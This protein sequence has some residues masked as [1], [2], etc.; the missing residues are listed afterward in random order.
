MATQHVCVKR[1]APPFDQ[2]IVDGFH[3]SSDSVTHYFLTHAHADHTTGLHASWHAGAIHCSPITARILRATL[4][5]RPHLLHP[6][7]PGETRQID[8]VAVTA[9]DAHHCP[10]ALMFLFA[11]PRHAALHTGDCRAS[12]LLR[13]QLGAAL[14]GA[15]LGALYLDT[16]YAAPRHAFPPQA[17]AL[18]AVDRLV[19]AELAREPATLFVVGSYSVGKEA[20]IAAA[21]AAAGGRALVPPRRAQMLRLC[22]EWDEAVHADA[23]ADDVRVHVTPLGAGGEA[24]AQLLAALR[25]HGGRFKAAVFVRPTGWT[26]SEAMWRDGNLAPRVWAENGG[27]TRVYGVPYSEHSAFPELQELVRM[28][29][30]RLLVPTVNAETRQKRERLVAL[31][32]PLLDHSRDKCKLDWH[33]KGEG[34]ASASEGEGLGS[35]DVETQR[36]LWQQLHDEQAAEKGTDDSLAPPVEAAAAAAAAAEAM[37]EG[38]AEEE[39]EKQAEEEEEKQAEDG[40][41]LAVLA[42]LGEGT[43]AA[44]VRSLL[45]SGGDAETAIAIHFGANEGKVPAAYTSPAAETDLEA[46]RAAEAAAGGAPADEELQLPPGTVAWVLGKEFRL[47]QSREALHARLKA[48]GAAVVGEGRRH[49]K[50]EVTLIVIA[51]GAEVGAVPRSACPAAAVVRESWVVRRA[52]ALRGG[53]IAPASPAPPA[54][55]QKKR[56]RAPSVA[57]GEK[58]AARTRGLSAAASARQARALSERLYLIEQRDESATSPSGLLTHRRTFAVLGSTGNVYTVAICRLPSCTCV[59]HTER[60][61]V[62]KHLLFVYHKVL[63][64]PH[65]SVIPVQRA[66]LRSELRSILSSAAADSSALDAATLASSAVRSAYAQAMG[67]PAAPIPSGAPRAPPPDEPCAICFEEID[68]EARGDEQRTARCSHGCGRL[69]HADCLRRWFESGCARGLQCPV[70]RARCEVAAEPREAGEEAEVD[71]G[72]LNLRALQPG[73]QRARDSSTYSSWLEVHERNREAASL[74]SGAPLTGGS[75]SQHD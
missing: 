59:D 41:V 19:R 37:E 64:V 55:Q 12:P 69:Y 27:A 34:A 20:V 75:A 71:E 57:S 66:L 25:S 10:G 48:L 43:P 44:Y 9:L 54:T 63:S 72:Y 65:D 56:C 73:V 21:A 68:A 42:V 23:D 11:T 7:A 74:A 5:V 51:E 50:Q 17:A 31:F 52:M 28:L 49:S 15:R 60:K 61:Q 58:R 26:Y 46:E 30:P 36:R 18:D 3:F 40:A 45:E 53:R 62:C 22:G 32:A 33:F 8:G 24:H 29:R 39:E 13:R 70:C 4:G 6:I 2:F 16:T 47:Y 14:R 1:L 38:Q 67:A 35:V